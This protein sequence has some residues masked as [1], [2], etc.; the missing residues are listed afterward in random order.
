MKSFFLLSITFFIVSCSTQKDGQT[1]VN[2]LE[3][4]ENLVKGKT[5]QAQAL[6][7][8]GAPEVVEKSPD[9]DMWAYNKH[10]NESQS[11]GGSISHRVFYDYFWRWSGVDINADTS[12]TSTKTA[13]LV[14][15][16]NT[17]KI[18]ANYTFRTDKY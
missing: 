12:T 4:T 14:L 2:A 3:V 11:Q 13:S 6:E 17:N 15:Y 9:G 18:L 10:S 5:T 8:F 1:K 16:F 7:T